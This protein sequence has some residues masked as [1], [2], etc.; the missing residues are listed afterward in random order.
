MNLALAPGRR[1]IFRNC[2]LVKRTSYET[3][4]RD[5]TV[6]VFRHAF[7]TPDYSGFLVYTGK[8]LSIQVGETVTI[9]GT[10]KREENLGP[11]FLR[12][13]RPKILDNPP[14]SFTLS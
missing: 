2:E 7:K 14:R 6:R 5:E 3:D 4:F 8:L 10:I 11:G 13:N 1:L 12:I 9:K